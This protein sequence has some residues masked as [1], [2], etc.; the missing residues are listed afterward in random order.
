MAATI[1]EKSSQAATTSVDGNPPQ[2]DSKEDSTLPVDD[3]KK[4]SSDEY[5]DV[6]IEEEQLGVYR[7]LIATTKSRRRR[8][9]KTIQELRG[10]IPYLVAL[11]REVYSLA[12]G[13]FVC[14][15]LWKVWVGLEG[16][17]LLHLSTRML[18]L[19]RPERSFYVVLSMT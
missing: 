5:E 16:A 1:E 8:Y 7:L 4:P 12:P 14:L 10:S 9:L 17:V 19:V 6:V 18:R 2:R 15:V 11:F 13:L 3:D